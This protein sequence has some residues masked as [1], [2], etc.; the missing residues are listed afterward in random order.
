MVK[1]CTDTCCVPESD[2]PDYLVLNR[3]QVRASRKPHPCVYCGGEIPAG[4]AC[5]S[6]TFL[7]EGR[8]ETIYRHYPLTCGGGEAAL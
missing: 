6:E 5:S 8:A 1:R 4:S 3:R 7:S 2:L